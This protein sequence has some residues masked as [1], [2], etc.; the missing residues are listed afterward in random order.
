LQQALKKTADFAKSRNVTLT[1][2]PLE[3]GFVAGNE[4][5]LVRALHALVETAVKFAAD[6][7][8][9]S[10]AGEHAPDLRKV[11]VVSHGR[12]IPDPLVSKFFDLL[13]IGEAI[14]PGG[15]LGLGP[16]LAFRILSLFG[17]SVSVENL[18]PP[19][20][21]LTISLKVAATP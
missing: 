4:E 3:M 13:S 21:R 8:T 12:A 14:T 18:E 9:L 2:P 1:P 6:G 10:L 7:E 15:D 5:L 17:G 16:P 19:G 20:I 11:I